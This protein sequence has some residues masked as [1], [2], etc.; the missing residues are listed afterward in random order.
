MLAVTSVTKKLWKNTLV[1][2]VKRTK[3]PNGGEG[4][5]GI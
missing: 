1:T 3:M 2:M 5:C 4:P